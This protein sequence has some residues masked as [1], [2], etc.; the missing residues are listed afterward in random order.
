M[1]ALAQFLD[2]GGY[3]RFVWPAYGLVTMVMIAVL[4]LGLARLRALTRALGQAERESARPSR[5]A[6]QGE[7]R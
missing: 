2:M 6:D 5:L 3:A 7:Q 4:A 1:S